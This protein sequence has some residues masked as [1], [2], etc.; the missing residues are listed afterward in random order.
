MRQFVEN[1]HDFSHVEHINRC[2]HDNNVSNMRWSK[3][4]LVERRR[5][6]RTQKGVPQ[7]YLDELPPLAELITN[8]RV[9]AN[10]FYKVPSCATFEFYEYFDTG[11][12]S[13][14][15]LMSELNGRSKGYY[16]KN[17]D[18]IQLWLGSTTVLSL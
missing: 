6:R 17:P 4:L 15:R 16:F 7:T 9:K 18:G 1:P 14:H 2:N 13:G 11:K 5:K 8:P 10:T 12:E 3:S